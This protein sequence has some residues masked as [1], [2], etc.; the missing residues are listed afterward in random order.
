MLDVINIDVDFQSERLAAS[1]ADSIPS[2]VA[3]FSPTTTASQNELR[4]CW[5]LSCIGMHFVLKAEE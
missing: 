1:D 3:C 5:R 4:V 2:V